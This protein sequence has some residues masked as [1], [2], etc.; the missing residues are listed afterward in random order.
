MTKKASAV[1]IA[2]EGEVLFLSSNDS[3]KL[4]E[5]A[6]KGINPLPVGWYRVGSKE[7]CAEEA[8]ELVGPAGSRLEIF[9]PLDY[10]GRISNRYPAVVRRETGSTE[11]MTLS[12]YSIE[13]VLEC[14]FD[15][16]G[17]SLSDYFE[18][19]SEF[20]QI[21]LLNKVGDLIEFNFSAFENSYDE[22]KMCWTDFLGDYLP[23][24]ARVDEGKVDKLLNFVQEDSGFYRVR[25]YGR[26]YYRTAKM[27]HD[28]LELIRACSKLVS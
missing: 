3:S 11:I 26:H 19:D 22:L 7:F 5:L 15:D 21:N 23:E 4:E 25:R 8:P 20:Y 2:K 18:K 27:E 9:L 1:Y 6:R 14:F 13:G 10:D 24:E 12:S 17:E 28:P 16:E